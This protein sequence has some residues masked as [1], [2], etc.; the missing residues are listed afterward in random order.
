MWLLHMLGVTVTHPFLQCTQAFKNKVYN[1][2]FN[3]VNCSYRMQI[4][5][6]GS[7]VGGK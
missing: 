1:V 7:V 2:L 3:G 5:A 6:C 4:R